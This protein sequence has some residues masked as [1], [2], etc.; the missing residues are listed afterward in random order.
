MGGHGELALECPIP[1]AIVVLAQYVLGTNMWVSRGC[2]LLFFLLA[3]YYFF[4]VVKRLLG[5]EIAEWSTVVYMALP[6]GLFYSRA[7]H[8]DFFALAVVHASIYYLLMG[9]HMARTLPLLASALLATVAAVVKIPYLFYWALPVLAY[10]VR[11]KQLEWLLTRSAVYII[12]L[13][14]FYLWQQ[15]A[16]GINSAAPDWDYLLHYRKFDDNAHWYFGSVAQRLSL[17]NWKVIG[18]RLVTEVGAGLGCL[19]YTSPSPRD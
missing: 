10:T 9:L 4:G 16:Y 5:S 13:S 1:E 15:H 7:I 12:P 19:L 8:I 11:Q 2:F 6:L 17:Y 18:W 3:A 14:V